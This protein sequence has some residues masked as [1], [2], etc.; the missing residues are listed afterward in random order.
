MLS[1]GEGRDPVLSAVTLIW[2]LRSFDFS[3]WFRALL[4]VGSLFGNAGLGGAVGG[5]RVCRSRQPAYGVTVASKMADPV[6]IIG[7]KGQNSWN[8]VLGNSNM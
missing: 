2:D 7:Q 3:V 8:Y 5:A 6:L 4:Q 1:P